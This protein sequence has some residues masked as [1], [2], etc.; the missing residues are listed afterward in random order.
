MKPLYSACQRLR[1]RLADDL[2]LHDDLRAHARGW[3]VEPIFA[4]TGRRYR[5]PRFDDL[6]ECATCSG[7]GYFG[8]ETCRRCGGRGVIDTR[9]TTAVEPRPAD[10]PPGTT[11]PLK[12]VAERLDRTVA[13]PPDEEER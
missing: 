3:T 12:V 1:R 2:F 8:S 4:G 6:H 9:T 5:D 10:D 7:I 11:G 13:L